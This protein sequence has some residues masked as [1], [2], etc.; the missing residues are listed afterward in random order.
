M[1]FGGVEK[2]GWYIGVMIFVDFVGCIII[3]W[4][5]ERYCC[6]ICVSINFEDVYLGVFVD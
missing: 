5:E 4:G 2:G 1:F 3:K 6:I